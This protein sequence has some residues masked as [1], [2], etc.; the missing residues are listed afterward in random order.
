LVAPKPYEPAF[1]FSMKPTMSAKAASCVSGPKE[2]S[3]YQGLTLN[4]EIAQEY[5][6][7]YREWPMRGTWAW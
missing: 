7:G 2:F 4:R 5:A 1:T 6:M 3:K